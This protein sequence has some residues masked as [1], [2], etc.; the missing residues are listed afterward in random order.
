MTVSSGSHRLSRLQR[1]FL[2]RFSART[3]AFFLTGGA[4]LVEW[5]LGHR[6]TDDL[7]LFTADDNA[8]AG[9]DRLVRSVAA[10]LGAT[11]DEVTGARVRQLL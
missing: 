10:E 4:V 5:I 11:V 7:D 8:I 6:R 1:E 9:A 3:S 2:R